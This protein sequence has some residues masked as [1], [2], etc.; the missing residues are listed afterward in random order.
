MVN[1]LFQPFAAWMVKFSALVA[2]NCRVFEHDAK[3]MKECQWLWLHR[4]S[5]FGHF[6]KVMASFHSNCPTIRPEE[7]RRSS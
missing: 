4:C 5:V 1:W 7:G 6:A 3:V 2:F